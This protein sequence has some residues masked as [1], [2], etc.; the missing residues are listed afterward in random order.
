MQFECSRCPPLAV[1]VKFSLLLGF[2]L[3][4]LL[5]LLIWATVR[6]MSKPRSLFSSYVRLLASHFQLLAL[7]LS[8]RFQ[9]PGSV[10]SLLAA[11]SSVA[12]AP[13]Q[14]LSL[15]CLFKGSVTTMPSFYTRLILITILLPLMGFLTISVSVGISYSCFKQDRTRT[16]CQK[17]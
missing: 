8:F 1:N 15:D 12:D 7:L 13:S 16:F 9:W 14:L 17:F 11:F 2:A 3:L 10:S 5:T 4:A 6:S